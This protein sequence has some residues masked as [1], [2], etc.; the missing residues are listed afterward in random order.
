MQIEI[1]ECKTGGRVWGYESAEIEKYLA[2]NS[3]V[4]HHFGETAFF[5]ADSGL[6]GYG[7]ICV[8]AGNNS[9]NCVTGRVRI[10]VIA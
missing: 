2:I 4:K 5:W 9:N 8:P 7:Q 10:D 3:A 6:P 1:V